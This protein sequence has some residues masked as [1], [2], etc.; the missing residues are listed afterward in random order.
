MYISHVL[1]PV[2]KPASQCIST[3]V[4][5]TVANCTAGGCGAACA[6]CEIVVGIHDL[7]KSLNFCFPPPTNT[8]IEQL[9]LVLTY[10]LVIWFVRTVMGDEYLSLKSGILIFKMFV[11]MKLWNTGAMAL[12][13]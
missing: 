4:V 6:R 3:Y 13:N 2:L 10:L 1:H 5:C 12:V 11:W 9:A 7:K 8:Y